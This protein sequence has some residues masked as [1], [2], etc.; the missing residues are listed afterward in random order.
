MATQATLGLAFWAKKNLLNCHPGILRV[1]RERRRRRRQPLAGDRGRDAVP[2]RLLAV[3]RGRALRHHHGHD[4]GHPGGQHPR[5]HR[6]LHRAQ[7]DGRAGTNP[8]KSVFPE[9]PR[10]PKEGPIV[11]GSPNDL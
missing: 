7:P 3:R 4:G 8:L 9:V 10:N 2:Q 11:L 6:H 1:E 5:G